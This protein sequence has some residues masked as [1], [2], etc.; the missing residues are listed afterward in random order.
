M[1]KESLACKEERSPPHMAGS[2]AITWIAAVLGVCL[3]LGLAHAKRQS[4][5]LSLSAAFEAEAENLTFAVEREVRLFLDVLGSLGRVHSISA[6]VDQAAFREFVRKG[7][8]Y[9]RYILG[10]FGWAPRVDKEERALFEQA[11]QEA[12][13]RGFEVVQF[14]GPVRLEREPTREEYFP[15]SYVEPSSS[16]A[17]PLGLDLASDD[18]NRRALTEAR[19]ARDTIVSQG[20]WT[21]PGRPSI[22]GRYAFSPIY[23][24]QGAGSTNEQHG[25]YVVA[26]LQPQAIL[27]KALEYVTPGRMRV[28]ILDRTGP[29]GE[30]LIYSQVDN[31][32]VSGLTQLPGEPRD[33]EATPE[34]RKT[35]SL[36][37]LSWL[38]VCSPSDDF[39]AMYHS[40]I[41]WGILAAGLLFTGLLT[42]HLFHLARHAHKVECT[43]Q[44]RTSELTKSI[45]E[46]RRLEKEVLDVSTLEKRRVGQ[47]LHDSLGQHLTGIGLLSSALEK[48]LTDGSRPEA[49]HASRISGLMKEAIGQVR[50]IARGLSPVEMD[51]EGLAD[52]LD[53]LAQGAG[54]VFEI[55]CAF[56]AKNPTSIYDNIVAINLYHI[57]QE[58]VN[59]AARHGKPTHILLALATNETGGTLE[60]EDN[61]EGISSE[62]DAV[63]GM[64]LKI[65]KYRAEMIG[66]SLHVS[67][68]ADGGTRVTCH[69]ENRKPPKGNGTTT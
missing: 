5:A 12:G 57:A 15:V 20:V 54:E 11:M 31:P 65:M 17:L 39:I 36:A 1:T 6:D 49:P 32:N 42:M 41:P 67:T 68:P 50:R 24:L 33:E 16:V 44:E 61:G 10:I 59:N 66:G 51:A 30:R 8:L 22:Y 53:R 60:I 4:E 46:R 28:H 2:Y 40:W 47:D 19:D 9:H 55:E 58:A 26:L 56:T 7:L 43:V 45:A 34:F 52:A 64:G 23:H 14:V 69:F 21:M 25:G 35:L 38:I 63:D 48:E 27:Q 18:A 37:G 62:M 13:N 29:Q 3:T